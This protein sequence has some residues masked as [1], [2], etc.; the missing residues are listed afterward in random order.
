MA[1]PTI[2]DLIGLDVGS[3]Y[4]GGAFCQT[5]A[6]SDIDP[7]TLDIG[8]R[9]TGGAFCGNPAA[10]GGTPATINADPLTGA[11]SALALSVTK[12]AVSIAEDA[13]TAASTAPALTVTKGAVSKA[14]AALTGAVSACALTVVRGA[15]SI[16]QDA[17][18]AISSACTASLV[19]GA[20]TVALAALTVVS[21]PQALTVGSG[22]AAI[23]Q[24]ALSANATLP[25]PTVSTGAVTID[26]D[27]LTAASS[28]PSATLTPGAA[29]IDA[30]ALTLAGSVPSASILTGSTSAS[31]DALTIASSTPKAT[32]TPG[33]ITV[34]FF[35]AP[36]VLVSSA[37]SCMVTKGVASVAV[38]ALTLASSAPS[39]GVASTVTIGLD[40]LTAAASTPA[41][42]DFVVPGR[43]TVATIINFT[44]FETGGA[45]E[46]S[47]LS[48]ATIISTDNRTGT[49]C[50]NVKRVS[51]TG[52]C[53]ARMARYGSTGGPTTIGTA[54]ACTS[55]Y[56][57]VIDLPSA[58]SEIITYWLNSIGGRMGELRLVS[59]GTL[60]M[61]SSDGTTLG[62]TATA[63]I[64]GTWYCIGAY[65]ELG[66]AGLAKVWIDGNLEIDTAGNGGTK[67]IDSIAYGIYVNRNGEAMEVN[68]DDIVIFDSDEILV[69]HEVKALLTTANGGYEEWQ[70]DYTAVDDPPGS[71]SDADYIYTSKLN[72]ETVTVQTRAAAGITAGQIKG[73]K[74]LW[75]V[76]FDNITLAD[77][78][79]MKLLC[80]SNGSDYWTDAASYSASFATKSII[81]PTDPGTGLA[82]EG[83]AVDAVELGVG[84]SYKAAEDNAE[85]SVIHGHI[86]YIPD[87]SASMDALALASSAPSLTVVLGSAPIA[88]DALA[89]S[90]AAMQASVTPGACTTVMDALSASAT[91][92]ALSVTGGG[93]PVPAGVIVVW[94]S[95]V[96]SIPAGW[97]RCEDL[98]SKYAHV[99]TG[100]TAGTTGGAGGHT[101]SSSADH[102][103]VL[104]SHTHNVSAGEGSGNADCD[105]AGATNYASSPTHTHGN[106]TSA[107]ATDAITA[108]AATSGVASNLLPSMRV[109]WIVSDGTAGMPAGA[110]AYFGGP[111]LPADWT[112]PTGENS[113][114][115]RFLRGAVAGAD[116]GTYHN[117]GYTTHAHTQSHTHTTDGH[118]H[119]AAGSANATGQ[120]VHQVGT[121]A[122][123]FAQSTH[124]HQVSWDSKETTTGAS[125]NALS[126]AYGFPKYEKLLVI[127]NAIGGTDLPRGVIGLWLG[128]IANIPAGWVQKTSAQDFIMGA[129]DADEIGDT[130]GATTHTHSDDVH[131]HTIAS[132]T[133]TTAT[134]AA[135]TPQIGH[136]ADYVH[137]HSSPTH[138]H[139]WETGGSTSQTVADGTLAWDDC[140]AKAAYPE[141]VEVILIE[142]RPFGP[143]V[144]ALSAASSA[145]SISVSTGATAVELDALTGSTT[146]PTLTSS[147]GAVD[148]ALDP[149]AVAASAGALHVEAVAEIHLGTAS[150]TIAP[151]PCAVA[152]GARVIALSPSILTGSAPSIHPAP[153]AK[154]TTL[155][156]LSCTLAATQASA[157]PCPVSP[158]MDALAAYASVPSVG[159]ATGPVSRTVSALTLEAS[160]NLTVH[161]VSN[162][163]CDAL[164]TSASVGG[165]TI[166]G[167]AVLVDA[168]SLVLAL[169]IR[170]L[171]RLGGLARLPDHRGIRVPFEDRVCVVPIERRRIIVPAEDRRS[172]ITGG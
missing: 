93:E 43:A 31:L 4:T 52:T 92:P 101:H 81:Y 78:T 102:T 137:Y 80:R 18:S 88:L 117:T 111:T 94:P 29:S 65:R 130:G 8:S 30:D 141:Y 140:D 147:N 166:T 12:G 89:L 115:G 21:A 75:R 122:G 145:P 68:I 58:N 148:I 83:A 71:L 14:M 106:A 57:R 61:L 95:T 149:L 124:T 2:T 108:G 62:T 79:M 103:H 46:L 7:T 38:D 37:P 10:A 84:L 121:T 123:Y 98:D 154:S 165:L 167:G 97:S 82:W 131:A 35:N 63:L 13:L 16:A 25:V 90:A 116:G 163:Q 139:T 67:K 53:Y 32:L 158:I 112:Q 135:G 172:V 9:Y 169:A 36:A 54:G 51:G 109:I 60:Q 44:G 128:T 69:N 77:P 86:L 160:T 76:R 153:G 107:T 120:S 66:A 19:P 26:L 100:D 152:P 47:E 85:C 146:A 42:E 27:C 15:M 143:A 132:H 136:R 28:T 96:A 22:A 157:P 114:V 50:L 33:P 159:H 64:E 23:A 155:D 41:N 171:L 170:R 144:N 72:A 34:L 104:G 168:D 151:L 126:A 142:R 74:G 6:K 134:A 56:M 40:A 48:G 105:G 127:E 91:T 162:I 150:A 113:P 110:C 17:L 59:D 5:V 156:P 49:Y 119:A 118:V 1:L 138:T 24:D 99:A 11:S 73:L 70:N 45:N 55:F 87:L 20:V 39:L 133:H 129:A 164:S 161:A 3:R 125:A